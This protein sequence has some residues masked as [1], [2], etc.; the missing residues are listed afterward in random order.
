MLMSLLLLR[1]TFLMQ[2]GCSG[3]TEFQRVVRF[4]GLATLVQSVSNGY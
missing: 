3:D 4:M 1:E 2:S